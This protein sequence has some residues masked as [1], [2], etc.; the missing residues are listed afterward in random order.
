MDKVK[1]QAKVRYT[2]AAHLAANGQRCTPERLRVLDATLSLKGRF[3]AQALVDLC[4]VKGEG[5]LIAVS[6]ATVFNTLPKLEAAGIIRRLAHD[7]DIIYEMVRPQV[8]PRCRQ[9]LV[10]RQCGKVK[11]LEAPL[12][13]AWVERQTFR[14][15][16]PEADSGVLYIYGLCSRCHRQQRRAQQ[17]PNQ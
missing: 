6:R 3:S 5:D 2:F 12:L 15:F 7:R 16:H 11:R 4:T 1:Q 8:R 9:H 13:S 14:D 10:C 17:H